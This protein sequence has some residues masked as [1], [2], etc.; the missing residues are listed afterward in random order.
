MVF[1]PEFEELVL[2]IQNVEIDS[3]LDSIKKPLK[4]PSQKIPQSWLKNLSL[5]LNTASSS[6]TG[7]VKLSSFV[8]LQMS[9]GMANTLSVNWLLRKMS[10]HCVATTTAHRLKSLP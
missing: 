10:I 4:L 9:L 5:V 1:V 2:F 3:L 6:W 7:I 8:L